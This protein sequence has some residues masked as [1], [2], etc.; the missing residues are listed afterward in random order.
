MQAIETL[1]ERARAAPQRIVL[2]EGEDD[3]II[4]AAA[5]AAA[6]RYAR[7]TLLGREEVVR[8]SAERLGVSLEGVEVLDFLSSTQLDAYARIYYERRRAKGTTPEEARELVRKPLYF[9]AVRV[10]TGDAD[11]TVGGATNSTAETIR[12][13]LRSIGLAFGKKLVSSFFLMIVPPQQGAVFGNNGAML[14]ADCGVVPDPSAEELAEIALATAENARTL[15]QTE[16]RVALLSFSTKG[17]AEH[18]RVD[19]V[20]EAV[21]RAKTQEPGLLV[22]GELQADAAL[23]FAIGASKAPG[24]PVAPLRSGESPEAVT[25]EQEL[26]STR[27]ELQGAVR[28]LEISNDEQRAIN[29]EALSVQEEFQSTNEELLTSKEELQSLNEELTALNSQL[30][31]TL[32]KQRTTADDLQ[33]VLYSTDVAIIFLDANLRIR[34]FTPATRSLFNVI[35]GDIGRPLADL[36]SLAADE[37]LLTDA[38]T[39]LQTLTPIEREIEARG[40]SWYSRRVLPYRTRDDRVEGVVITFSDITVRTHAA[41]AMGIAQRQAEQARRRDLPRENPRSR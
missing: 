34:F 26:E 27:A 10:A 16:P 7:P 13:A 3:R 1:K 41:D 11:G 40:G 36:K 24:S 20:R 19:K 9:A 38:R 5:V 39:V 29:E 21:R 32:E 31:E 33:N 37:A 14:F 30:Q 6:E 23:V 17:S 8:A 15:L 22:D 4:T 28:A 2:P 18:E 25:L 12:A 35:P